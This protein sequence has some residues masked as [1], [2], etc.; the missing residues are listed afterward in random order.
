MPG[1]SKSDTNIALTS[2]ASWSGAYVFGEGLQ[3][4]NVPA[5]QTVTTA[6]VKKGLS[7]IPQ[8]S[9]NHGFTP[10]VYYG[11]GTTTP[12][13]AINCFWIDKVVNGDYQ[14]I[15]D[16]TSVSNQCESTDLLHYK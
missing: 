2:A 13:K 16:I 6:D 14:L 9:T 4:A 1:G 5:S 12:E 15:G 8:G 7:M 10:P 11:D 3:N